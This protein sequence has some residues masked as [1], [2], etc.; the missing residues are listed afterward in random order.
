MKQKTD[1][2]DT[3]AH[4][5]VTNCI[6]LFR[7]LRDDNE[8][9]GGE[10]YTYQLLSHSFITKKGLAEH[11]CSNGRL[12]QCACFVIGTAYFNLS[13]NEYLTIIC[14]EIMRDLKTSFFLA[15][16]G[17]YRQ[18]IL[19]QRCI[20]ENFLYGL[21]FSAEHYKFNKC[22]DDAT[23]NQHN[24]KSWVKG[25]FRKQESYLLDIIEKAEINT[26]TE[27]KEWKSLFNELSQF[28]HTILHTPMG[29]K[30]I[31]GNDEIPGCFA[32]VEFSEDG[33]IEWSGYFRKLVFLMLY[34]LLTLYPFIKKEGGGKLALRQIRAEFKSLQSKIKDPYLTQILKMRG[35]S[36]KTS[37][38]NKN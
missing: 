36:Y 24:F 33:L 28:V 16:C 11:V 35:T 5:Q 21:Y 2:R 15:M 29:R 31:D 19:L 9:A 37:N 18:A 22:N 12:L 13:E 27:T 17:H 34:K 3:C 26:K 7:H 20:L 4:C 23:T 30:I 1:L 14:N 8:F 10:L 6:D 25:G 38:A 32:E